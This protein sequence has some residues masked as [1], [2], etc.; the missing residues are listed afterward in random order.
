[1]PIDEYYRSYL[2]V[3]LFML[4]G[5][6]LFGAMIGLARVLQPRRMNPVKTSVYE[7]GVDPIGDEWSQSQVRYY[8]FGLLFVV[9]DV[10]AIFVFPWATVMGGLGWAGLVEMIVF[11]AILAF[12]LLYAVRKQLLR[13][14]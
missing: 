8:V 10:E 12:A 13:W 14:V 2:T 3:A 11:I 1:V 5:L 9:F 6:G 7:C 4:L